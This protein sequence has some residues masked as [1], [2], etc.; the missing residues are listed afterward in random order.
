MSSKGLRK[1]LCVRGELETEQNCN[2]LTPPT[3]LATAA[4]LSHSPGQLNRGPGGPASAWTWFSFQHLLSNCS[5]F[6]SNRGYKFVWRSHASCDVTIRTQFN[7]STVEVIPRYL[8]P[9]APVIYTGP[10]LIWLLGRVGGQYVTK[11]QSA[12]TGLEKP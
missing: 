7:P 12:N 1:V 10:F 8:R 2:I 11:R 3:L 4:F 9:D 6:L 5:D